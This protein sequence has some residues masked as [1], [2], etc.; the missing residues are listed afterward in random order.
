MEE[1]SPFFDQLDLNCL[2]ILTRD[3]QIDLPSKD[4]WLLQVDRITELLSSLEDAVNDSG[5]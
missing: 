5:Q 4:L 1:C 2:E 3:I